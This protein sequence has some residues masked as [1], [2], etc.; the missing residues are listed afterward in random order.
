MDAK[1]AESLKTWKET[2]LAR[3]K[4]RADMPQTDSVHLGGDREASQPSTAC[5]ES[6][7]SDVQNGDVRFQR[8]VEFLRREKGSDR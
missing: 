1:Q 4:A 3:V 5:T 2:L 6:R 7:I 8:A